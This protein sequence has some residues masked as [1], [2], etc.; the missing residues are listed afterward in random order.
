MGPDI[1]LDLKDAG[2]QNPSKQRWSSTSEDLLCMKV[3]AP[4]LPPVKH[5][6]KGRAPLSSGRF[7]NWFIALDPGDRHLP[8]GD[9]FRPCFLVALP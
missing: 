9:T 1:S 2:T 7:A 5:A 4:Q 6:D 8:P 3:R